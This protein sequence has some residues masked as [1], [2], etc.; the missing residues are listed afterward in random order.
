MF[1]L[2]CIQ[3]ILKPCNDTNPYT[4][5]QA[6]ILHFMYYIIYLCYTLRN[7]III[8]AL[9]SH[10][11]KINWEEQKESHLP[12]SRDKLPSV[13]LSVC[14]PVMDFFVCPLSENAFNSPSLMKSIF[15]R[16]SFIQHPSCC[17]Y[18]PQPESACF[19]P[20]SSVFQ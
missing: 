8:I 4:P 12:L 7:Y 1:N 2:Y 18:S 11:F 14:L 13:F 9:N 17:V 5:P 6:F 20:L 19:H 10:I 3:K 15:A 16:Q